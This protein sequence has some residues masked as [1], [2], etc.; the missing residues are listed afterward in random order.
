MQSRLDEFTKANSVILGLA[1][2]KV[3]DNAKLV[4]REGLKIAILADPKLEAIDA[5]GLRHKGA[6]IDGGDVSRPA[7]FIIDEKGVVRHSFF[8]DNWRVRARA[9]DLLAELKKL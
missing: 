6:S 5:F 9:E 4:K 8:P 3:E 7:I 2:D 1:A